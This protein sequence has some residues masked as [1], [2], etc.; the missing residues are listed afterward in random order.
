MVKRYA[1][2]KEGDK[3]PDYSGTFVKIKERFVVVPIN[4]SHSKLAALLEEIPIGAPV[5]IYSDIPELWAFR[6]FFDDHF[7]CLRIDGNAA[8]IATEEN[9]CGYLD[10]WLDNEPRFPGD[11]CENERW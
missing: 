2:I 7:C 11:D 10:E 9:N 3:Y 8:F 5:N 1:I 6:N 4:C